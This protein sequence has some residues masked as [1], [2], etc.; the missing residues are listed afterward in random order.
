MGHAEVAIT[1]ALM[2]SGL[3]EFNFGD[4][5]VLMLYLLLIAST[6]IWSRLKDRQAEPALEKV[7]TGGQ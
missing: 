7:R 4:S 1:V 5:E 2:V 6:F 3:F